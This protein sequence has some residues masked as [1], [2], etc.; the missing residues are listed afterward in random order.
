MKFTSDVL[1]MIIY[2]AVAARECACGDQQ[3][4]CVSQSG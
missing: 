1:E 4:Q 2:F 3:G